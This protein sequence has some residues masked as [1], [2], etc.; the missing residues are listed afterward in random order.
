[1]SRHRRPDADAAV[2]RH[3]RQDVAILLRQAAHRS[4]ALGQSA[5]HGRM[6]GARWLRGLAS[7]DSN[8]QQQDEQSDGGRKSSVGHLTHYNRAADIKRPGYV[9][10][11]FDPRASATD[12]DRSIIEYPA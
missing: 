6:S 8:R 12:R 1:M 2:F 4:I 9:V 3:H 5:V 7:A 10:Q 11:A